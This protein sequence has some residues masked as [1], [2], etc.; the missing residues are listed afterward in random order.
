M[1]LVDIFVLLLF[2]LVIMNYK[3]FNSDYLDTSNTNYL[4][5]F[6]AL[7]IVLHHISQR[8]GQSEIFDNFLFVGEYG[9]AFFFA[10]SA[11]S[12]ITQYKKQESYMNNFLSKRLAKL[13]IPY[14]VFSI[15]YFI[16]WFFTYDKY[17]TSEEILKLLT[18]KES[19]I[20]SG[21]FLQAIILMYILFYISFKFVKSIKLACLTNTILVGIA[22]C[23]MI[24]FKVGYWE[25]NSL[26]AFPLGL[27]WGLY[28][29][30]IDN[31]MKNNYTIL[32]LLFSF[33]VFIGHNYV[34]I[35]ME[36]EIDDVPFFSALLANM[37]NIFF[38]IFFMLLALKLNFKNKF[39]DFIGTISL[40]FYL[41]HGMFIY[42]LPDILG[43]DNKDDFVYATLVLTLSIISAYVLHKFINRIQKNKRF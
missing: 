29:E 31:L 4:R 41:V 2:V 11:Y 40:E 28:K 23:I 43:K 39:F 25:Y 21:W 9:V 24:I 15:I 7:F 5:G 32:I 16:F 13:F 42:Y 36:L 37:K 26:L 30:K 27:F 3:N 35:L 10:L 17:R 34:D 12:L 20:I 6:F 38:V 8:S 14:L 33:L 18:R 19:I 1:A 22:I